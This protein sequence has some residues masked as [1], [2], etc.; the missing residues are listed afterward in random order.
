MEAVLSIPTDES[1]KSRFT[2][3]CADAGLDTATALNLFMRRVI[4]DKK[5]PF[6][7]TGNDDPFYSEKNLA[8]LDES[9][10]QL[11]AGHVVVKS[12]EELEAMA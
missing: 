5:I 2:T 10:R 7:I 4:R 8:R 12:M 1:V 3:F 9:F 6:E 11:E